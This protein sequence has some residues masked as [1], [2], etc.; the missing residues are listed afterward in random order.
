MVQ[1]SSWWGDVNANNRLLPRYHDGPSELQGQ[2]KRHVPAVLEKAGL[3]EIGVR[4]HAGRHTCARLFIEMAGRFEELQ[5][6]LGHASIVT[7]EKQYG[8]FHE[9]VAAANAVRRIYG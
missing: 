2:A 3:S 4:F 8:H 7:T 6:S 1:K 5:K 9:D